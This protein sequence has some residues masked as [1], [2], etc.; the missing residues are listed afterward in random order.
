MWGGLG[1]LL[2]AE[3]FARERVDVRDAGFFFDAFLGA[4]VAVNDDD[5]GL[6]LAAGLANTL[7]CGERG[8]ARGGS[9]FDDHNLEA[10]NARAFYLTA[11]AV[12]LLLLADYEHVDLAVSLAAGVHDGGSHWVGAHREATDV[13]ELDALFVEQVQEDAAHQDG[14]LVVQGDAAEVNVVVGLIARG[15]NDLAV[16]NGEFFNEFKQAGAV[17]SESHDSEFSGC[18]AGPRGLRRR[19]TIDVMMRTMFSSKIHRATVTHADL[20]YVGSV[21][22]DLDLLDAADILPGELVSIVDV[23]NGSRLETYT[24]AGE[25]GSGVIGINGAAA[26]LVNVGDLV[27]LIAYQSMT[28][29]EAR[30][31]EPKVVHVDERN[32]IIELGSD[33]AEA[34]A[35]GLSRPPYAVH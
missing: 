5:D 9:V 35:E 18:A 7:N 14:G 32:R 10:L 21:T 16:D 30:A 26:H 34:L 8:A 3:F 31:F 25:R 15:Q 19:R 29:E 11:H 24:I 33:P 4:G 28:T 20:H 2:E 6:D 13:G 1:L 12:G 17:F 22:V 23:T 27:I